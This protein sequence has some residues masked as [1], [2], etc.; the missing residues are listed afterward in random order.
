LRPSAT[1]FSIEGSQEQ[2]RAILAAD[3]TSGI[4]MDESR[5]DLGRAPYVSLAT[6]RKSGAAVATP[7]WCAPRDGAL[8]VFSAGDAGKVKRLRVNARA[9]LAVCD[10]RGALL[11][12]WH[13]ATGE[14]LRAPEDIAV[15]LGALRDKY[16]WQMRLAD[17]GARLTGRFE[18]R[19]YIRLRTT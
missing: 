19:A 15:A 18:R 2:L 3:A 6:F 10:V 5:T 16:G 14:L 8:Y 13:E 12:D 7:V 11:S 4:S 17:I 9:R 1:V